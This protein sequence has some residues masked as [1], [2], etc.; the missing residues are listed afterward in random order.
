MTEIKTLY[1]IWDDIIFGQ[2]K[3]EFDIKRI[4]TIL[5]PITIKGLIKSLNI[6]KG[7]YFNR[8]YGKKAFKLSFDNGKLLQSKEH[9]PGWNRL[10]DAI[11]LVQEYYSLKVLTKKKAVVRK[12]DNLGEEEILEVYDDLLSRTEYLKYLAQRINTEFKLIPV[13]EYSNGHIEDSFLFRFKNKRGDVL[14]IWENVN[15]RRATYFFKY[16][17][18]KRPN[19]LQNIENF[20]TREDYNHKR[21]L[22]S[23]SDRISKEIKRD[24]CFYKR[25][26]HYGYSEFKSEVEYLIAYS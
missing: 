1:I 15:A 8:L 17:E 25:Y 19:T 2:D 18:Q 24:L 23:G 10:M 6:V 7:E 20:I 4:K 16:N 11:E 12:I 13:L 22:L 21:S 5:H 26:S 14:V 3:I 9:S